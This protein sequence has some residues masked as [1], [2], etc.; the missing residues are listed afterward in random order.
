MAA[1]MLPTTSPE[2]THRSPWQ[3]WVGFW[4]PASDPTTLGFAR[5]VVGLLVLYTHLAYSLDLQSF[6]GKHGWYSAEFVQRE[7]TQYPWQVS[8]FWNWDPQEVV[9]ARVP[10]FPHRRKAVMDYI[11]GLPEEEAKRKQSLEFLRKLV[12]SDNP[13]HPLF[14]MRWFQEMGLFEERRERF[15]AVLLGATMPNEREANYINSVTPSFL[16]SLPEAE[17][18][19]I[20]N[21]VRAFWASL[22]LNRSD[23]SDRE[24]VLDHILELSPEYRK[25]F[26]MFLYNLPTDRAERDKKVDYLEYWNNEREKTIR[27]G[28]NIFSVW[29]HITDPTQMAV[30]HG[31]I[32]FSMLLFTLGLFTRVTSVIVW[33]AVVGYIHRTQQVLFGMDTMMNVLVFY[34]MIGNSGAALSLD[35]VIARYRAARASLARHGFIDAATQAFLN[36][37]PLSRSAGFSLRLIQVHF[38]FIYV[39]AGFS[40]LKGAAWWNGNAIWDVMVNPEFTLMQYEWYEKSI[41]AFASIKPLYHTTI[42]LSSWGTLFIEIAGPFLLWTRLRWLIILI[43][44]AMHAAIGVLMG[45]NLF[46]LLMV[47]MLVCFMPDYVIRDRLRGSANWLKLKFAYNPTSPQSVRAAALA[48]AVDIENQVTLVPEPAGS[49]PAFIDATGQR[50]SGEAAVKPFWKSLRLLSPFAWLLLLPGVKSRCAKRLFSQ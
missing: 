10:D 8:P 12:S 45:L 16:I 36:A 42:I 21:D 20:A 14:A 37:P 9:P 7:R 32:L 15:L 13:E 49:A 17:R 27:V 11:R 5:V 47:V 40:K 24:Y 2:P 3:R 50:Q 39:A 30:V 43:A 46:E 33:I 23:S 35:R 18:R 22:P 34:L 31:A 1:E 19:Q 29:F 6:F 44:T 28:H 48:V 38:C 25:A 26:V 41:R 4:F